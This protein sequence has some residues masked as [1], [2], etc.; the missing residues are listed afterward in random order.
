VRRYPEQKLGAGLLQPV[1]QAGAAR[2]VVED[3]FAAAGQCRDQR[4]EPEIVA[5]RAQCVEHSVLEPPV[6]RHHPGRGEQGV[7]AVQNP[8]RLAR[9]ARCEGQ[10]HHLVGVPARFCFERRS[11]QFAER[12]GIR[13]ADAPGAMQEVARAQCGKD[14]VTIGI[15]TVARLSNQCCGADAVDQRSDLADRMAAMQGRAADIAA[16]RAG[17]QR[18][19]C[20]DPARQPDGDAVTGADAVAGEMRPQ[21]V[22]GRNQLGIVEPAVAVAYCESPRGRLRVPLSQMVDRLVAP[23]TGRGIGG[24]DRCL[25]QG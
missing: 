6:A 22:G 16:A 25:Q 11:R 23:K 5:K 17:D 19:R 10:I 14:V 13:R 7:V 9:R 12:R 24:N 2:Q 4:T 21:P 20:L 18:D 1:E 15:G 3:Q 8:F